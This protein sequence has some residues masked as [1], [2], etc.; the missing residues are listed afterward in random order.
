VV[1]K[2]AFAPSFLSFSALFELYII[3]TA[4]FLS[5][6]IANYTFTGLLACSEQLPLGRDQIRR[7]PSSY[8]R[9]ED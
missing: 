6:L 3:L 9:M 1:T 4:C 8:V 7:G 5:K 2:L